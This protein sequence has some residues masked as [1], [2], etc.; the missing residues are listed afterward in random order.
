MAGITV[1]LKAPQKCNQVR[2]KYRTPISSDNCISYPVPQQKSTLCLCH[3]SHMA[4]ITISISRIIFSCWRRSRLGT[5]SHRCGCIGHH[6]AHTSSAWLRCLVPGWPQHLGGQKD[7]VP[8]SK[9]LHALWRYW[10]SFSIVMYCNCT[11]FW[12]LQAPALGE[13]KQPSHGLA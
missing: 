2:K 13:N 7:L 8:P 4:K 1:R 5:R 12:L 10:F 3:H 9:I 6:G 11:S